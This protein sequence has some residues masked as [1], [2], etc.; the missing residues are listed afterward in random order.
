M[1]AALPKGSISGDAEEVL[2]PPPP[3]MADLTV[4]EDG[5]GMGTSR[6]IYLVRMP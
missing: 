4:K 6:V 3:Q 5:D 1:R 2:L